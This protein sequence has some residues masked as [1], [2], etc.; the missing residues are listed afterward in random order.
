MAA[1]VCE[2]SIG[3]C[4]ARGCHYCA[5]LVCVYSRGSMRYI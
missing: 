5:M 3:V 2:V 1:M 4:M